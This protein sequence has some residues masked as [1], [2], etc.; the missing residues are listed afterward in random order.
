MLTSIFLDFAKVC[1]TSIPL[2]ATGLPTCPLQCAILFE[3]GEGDVTVS[4]A[5]MICSDI[6]STIFKILELLFRN[7][8]RFLLVTEQ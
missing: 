7:A 5:L 1:G 2:P 3:T 8:Q 4:R 6:V